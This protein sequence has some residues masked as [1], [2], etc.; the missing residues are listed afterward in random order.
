MGH[1][2]FFAEEEKIIFTGDT[3]F[4]L[5]CGKIFE[6][7]FEEMFFSLEKIKSLPKDTKVYFGHEYTKKNYDFCS[8][9]DDNNEYL[10]K[11]KL[12]ID[13]RLNNNWPTAPS[14]VGEE[15]N[16]NI[17]LRCSNPLIKAKLNMEKASS[18]EIFKKLRDLKDNF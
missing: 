17:F 14:T 6:G 12:W 2:A 1:I 11:K 3:L 4:S 16:T 18:L 8:K 13:L 9:Y 7:T 10:K 15:L 5:G